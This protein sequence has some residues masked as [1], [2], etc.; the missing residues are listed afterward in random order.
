LSYPC[1]RHIIAELYQCNPLILND[2]SSIQ[3]ILIEAAVQAGAE[4][5]DFAFKKLSPSR[6]CGVMIISESH[7]AIH[8]FAD[9]RYA[10]L[11]IYTFSQRI[12]PDEAYYYI[13]NQLQ[14][15]WSLVKELLRGYG[16][17]QEKL[18]DY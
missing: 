2:L 3:G 18:L 1:G 6:L 5:R 14:A 16:E 13:A 17:I 10:S 12:N 11:D 9:L 15:S 4:V 7:L 8:T